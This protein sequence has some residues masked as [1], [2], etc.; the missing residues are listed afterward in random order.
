MPSVDILIES[1][2]ASSFRVEQVRGMFDVPSATVVRHEWRVNLP[3]EEREW[4]IGLIVGPSGSGKTTVGR[5]L[6]PDALFHE[7]YKWPAEAAIVDGFP[8]DADGASITQS[9]SSVGFS[10]PPHWLKRYS[11]LSN[12][13]KF[14][15][16]LARLMMEN[17]E[18]VVFDEFTS[19]I[20][21]DAAMVSSS[22]IAKALRRR[23]RPRLV[24]LSCH[25]DIA[26]WLNPDWI[27]NVATGD[28]SWRS[29]QQRPAIEL[30]IHKAST[31]AWKLFR[32]HHYLT[33]DIHKGAQCFVVTWRETP[34][35]FTSY[36]HFVHPKVRNAKREHRTVV[37]PDYQ[38]AGIGNAVSEWLGGHLKAL[39]WRFQ[40]T[41]SHPAMIQ[42]RHGSAKWRMYRIGHTSPPGETS[43]LRNSHHRQTASCSRFT[44][45]SEYIGPANSTSKE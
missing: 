30:R 36:I 3:I 34:V 42:H 24:A 37:L 35:A 21:R 44:A 11:H 31:S 33:A 45:G 2:I 40:S 22:A 6:F 41:T 4:Q 28:F 5:R 13:Q 15:C 10:S 26:D 39:G 14:R 17:A 7:G 38:G 18:T 19:V 27:F 1:P 32:G 8:A 23:K 20:D 12:G 43:S 25:F 9:L 29:L 16:E